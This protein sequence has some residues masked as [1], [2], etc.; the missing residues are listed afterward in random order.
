MDAPEFLLDLD[1]NELMYENFKT[2][3]QVM[4][5][6]SFVQAV[7]IPDLSQAAS[8][9]NTRCLQYIQETKAFVGSPPEARG[10]QTKIGQCV[11]KIC[12]YVL[13]F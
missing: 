8:T 3:E 13:F 12:S 4:R 11:I 6:P 2:H 10:N 1:Q 7:N 5:I 9:D